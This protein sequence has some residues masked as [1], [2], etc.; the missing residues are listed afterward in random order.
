MRLITLDYETMYD[1]STGYCLKQ[2]NKGLTTEDYVADQRFQEILVSAKIDA[3]PTEWFS[4]TFKETDAWLRELDIP[5]AALLC[6]NTRFDGSIL[7]MKHGIYPKFYLDTLAMATPFFKPILKSLSLG[8]ICEYLGLGTKGDE[9]IRAEGKRR[10]DF[11]PYELEQYAI[12]CMNDTDLT[13]KLYKHLVKLYPPETRKTE[14]RL[15]DMVLRMYTQPQL[16]MDA[17]VY[18]AGLKIVKER[19]AQ[20]LT[21]MELKGI[22]KK[23]LG[24][25]KQFAQILRDHGIDPPMK[26]SLASLKRGDDPVI[27]TYAFGK[28]DPEFIELREEFENDLE[29]STLFDARTE[30]KSTQE[31]KRCEKFIGKATRHKVC[32]VAA[33]YYGCHTGRLIGTDGENTLNLP[34][35]DAVKNEQGRITR[36][37]SILREGIVAPEGHV[38]LCADLAQI[39]ARIAA[40]LAGQQDLLDEFASGGDPYSTFATGMFKRTVTKELAKSDPEIFI[41]RK[42]GKETIL[43]GWFG[44]G[45]KK[46]KRN[47]RAKGLNLTDEQSAAYIDFFRTR[48]GRA[49]VLWGTLDDALYSLV[50]RRT[51]SHIGPLHFKWVNEKDAAMVLPNGMNVLYPNLRTKKDKE[52]RPKVIYQNARDKHPKPLWGGVVTENAAQSLARIIIVDHM[53]DIQQEL[54]YRTALQVY[55][56]VVLS[57]PEN[58]VDRVKKGVTQIM[59]RGVDWLPN[60]PVEVEIK[61]G[62]H[63]GEV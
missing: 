49:K 43:G 35:P 19:K 63:Y 6:Q 8:A 37:A 22:T 21:E 31:E 52:G 54:G 30:T 42:C 60:L 7:A 40:A 16:E 13:Y 14:L 25:N 24:S 61:I 47:V 59:S 41:M 15:I 48:Y 26:D 17:G 50:F 5:S 27:Q 29:T 39:E 4:G 34:N 55:D 10:E 44:M 58:D 36:H 38:I 11:T 51:E 1:R 53:L 56:S 45:G 57:V 20:I 9:V 32:R 62:K 2:K 23:A 28:S 33:G 18:I 3:A 12:Y 46:F